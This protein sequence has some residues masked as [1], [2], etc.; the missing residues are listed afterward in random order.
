[1]EQLGDYEY[2]KRD[3][4][5]HGAFAVVFKGRLRKVRGS[6]FMSSC[7]IEM[8]FVP[9]TTATFVAEKV[10]GRFCCDDCYVIFGKTDKPLLHTIVNGLL[11]HNTEIR[12]SVKVCFDVGRRFIA[13]SHATSTSFYQGVTWSCFY[14]ALH[15]K[16]CLCVR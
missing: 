15:I 13:K 7:R 4:I 9:F 1:M 2:D 5:G 10:T 16:F 8:D 11:G 3:L 6:F 14:V 12:Y